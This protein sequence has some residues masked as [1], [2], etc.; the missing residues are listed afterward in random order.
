MKLCVVTA[1]FNNPSGLRVAAFDRFI[2]AIPKTTS[3]VVVVGGDTSIDFARR[4]IVPLRVRVDNPVWLK[5]N[6]MNL[7]WRAAS[8]DAYAFVDPDILF[9]RDDWVGATVTALEVSRVVQMF[10]QALDLDV[11]TQVDSMS[12]SRASNLTSS[13]VVHP[14]LAWAWRRETLDAM[15]GLLDWDISGCADSRMIAA[16]YG[17]VMTSR[18]S[19]M[20]PEFNAALEGWQAKA[21]QHIGGRVGYVPGAV[22]HLWHGPVA[23]RDYKPRQALLLKHQFKPSDLVKTEEGVYQMRDPASPLAQEM[24]AVFRW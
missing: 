20:H 22:A 13:T 17:H 7:G 4:G 21:A 5:E 3:V 23:E 6:L 16:F 18:P 9:L 1:L 8:A 2:A 14:G 12:V 15:G 11:N 19:G 24:K 10:S